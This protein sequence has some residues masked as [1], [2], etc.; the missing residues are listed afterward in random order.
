M[1]QYSVITSASLERTRLTFARP[2]SDAYRDWRERTCMQEQSRVQEREKETERER[3]DRAVVTP[4]FE[5]RS[6]SHKEDNDNDGNEENAANRSR[7]SRERQSQPARGQTRK[8]A[9]ARK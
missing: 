4:P 2:G 7:F 8:G 1:Y 5:A 3:M 6:K 9:F